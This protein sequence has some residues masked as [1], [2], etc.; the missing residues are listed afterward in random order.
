MVYQAVAIDPLLVSKYIVNGEST[1][2]FKMDSQLN[3][4][5]VDY[6][7]KPNQL[8]DL[9]LKNMQ[10][11][12]RQV[13]KELAVDRN[14]ITDFYN[15]KHIFV[16]GM[17][18]TKSINSAYAYLLGMYPFSI[19]GITFKGELIGPEDH[20][21][22]DQVSE[23]RESLDLG[24]KL[25]K[26]RTLDYFGGNRDFN[27][28]ED[29]FDQYPDI[30]F[31]LIKNMLEAKIIFEREFGDQLYESL[32]K[33]M[34]TDKSN[35]DF[36]NAVEYLEDY[37]T[38]K[39][40]KKRTS[41]TFDP[42]TDLLI[43]M[44]YKHYFRLGLFKDHAYIRVFTHSY[45]MNLIKEFILKSE[46][47]QELIYIGLQNIMLDT[48]GLSL[49]FGNHLTFLA[50]MHQLGEVDNYFP[51]F[52]DELTWSLY[53]SGGKYNVKGEYEGRNLILQS[54]ANSEG[55]IALDDFII[56][57]CSKLYFGD[58]YKVATGNE[59]PHKNLDSPK[60]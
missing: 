60:N 6:G 56:Y 26:N 48:L 12:G 59:D 1:P 37:V 18:D 40:N 3:T 17:A 52:S 11:K 34:K 4:T 8:T 9:G 35:I 25:C 19:N 28:L 57:I 27:F 24:D 47:D 54:K 38:A 41:Y 44:Y 14:V 42:D 22:T 32:A 43:E 55:E 51:S 15:P 58:I 10:N 53:F 7:K 50:V 39:F 23:V 30:K 2:T 16:R 33:F 5:K 21:S 49:H 31:D 13:K 36:F 45:F 46:S 29:Q 20:I